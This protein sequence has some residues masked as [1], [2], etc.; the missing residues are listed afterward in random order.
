MSKLI[1]KILLGTSVIG[2]TAFGGGVYYLQTEMAGIG[3][4]WV[5]EV[6]LP[7][8]PDYPQ[9]KM[10]LDINASGDI[11]F[12]TKSPYDMSVLFNQ[13]DQA[14][15]TT[16]KGDLSLPANASADNP[17]P[18]MIILHGSGGI[19][20]GR[21]DRYQQFYNDLGIATFVLDYYAPRGASLDLPYTNKVL[22]TTEID[23]IH[24]A[25]KAL[26]LLGTHPA[27]DG[28]RIG[29]TGYSYGG[30]VT[31]YLQDPRFKAIISPETPDFA[32]HIDTYGPCH[33]TMGN[34]AT[35]GA[36]Y[37]A[38]RGDQDASVDLAVCDKVEAVMVAN[39]TP[40]ESHVLKGAGHAWENNMPQVM[41]D[42]PFVFG[43]SFSFNPQ[44]QATVD[45]ALAP[46]ASENATRGERAFARAMLMMD[47]RH[48][49]GS[50][51]L[52]GKDDKA[53]Q[54]AKA[55]I[56]EFVGRTLLKPSVEQYTDSQ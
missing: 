26:D 22:S 47:A 17:V 7:V 40:V 5:S 38:L 37:L 45:D 8:F 20:P 23:I 29:V 15:D 51:Y 50:G 12:E 1:K 34:E 32:A 13:Y 31:R 25:I 52:V 10:Q 21:E 41:G 19:A 9:A 4:P 54:A 30:M 56:T 27:I 42:Y 36:P 39:G 48:C 53:D 46:Q 49:L 24:D 33:Q 35:T 43:C 14:V 44:G 55:L 16:G 6:D 18:A 11:Y 2:I 28:N 3:L